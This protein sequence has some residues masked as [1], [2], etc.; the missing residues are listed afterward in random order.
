MRFSNENENQDI[1]LRFKIRH[2]GCWSNSLAETGNVAHTIIVKPFKERKYILGAIEVQ[3]ETL[4]GFKIFYSGFKHSSSIREVTDLEATDSRRKH[5]RIIFREKYED[6]V[7]KVLYE[8]SSIF[9]SDFIDGTGEEIITI[10][11]K[12]DLYDIKKEL[13]SLGELFYF[14]AI[15]VNID[16]FIGTNF[17][18]TPQER[19][20]L[21]W[22]F[23]IGYYIVP[24]KI[25]L[26]DVATKVGLS[27]STLAESLRKAESKVISKWEYEHMFLH[28]IFSK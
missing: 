19:H 26:E 15:E 16:D 13:E 21:H 14:R 10:V 23:S 18:L 22:A 25:H 20:A 9:Q 5:Y 6:M 1:L 17:E 24:R 7:S 8:H 3:S 27:K 2:D 28:E 12:M 4:R 11:P